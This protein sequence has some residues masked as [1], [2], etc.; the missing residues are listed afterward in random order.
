MRLSSTSDVG[1]HVHVVKYGSCTDNNYIKTLI[2]MWSIIICYL[3]IKQTW[4]SCKNQLQTCCCCVFFC[5]FLH[6][7]G[8]SAK[9]YLQSLCW[10]GTYLL[11]NWYHLI[12]QMM[13]NQMLL[14]SLL[15][16]LFL[17]QGKRSKMKKWVF[18]QC[19]TFFGCAEQIFF[20]LLFY[21]ELGQI[22][23]FSEISDTFMLYML[24]ILSQDLGFKCPSQNHHLKKLFLGDNKSTLWGCQLCITAM[25]WWHAWCL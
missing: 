23:L 9:H 18:L 25:K 13:G 7:E 1:S 3:F 12:E 24:D 22:L 21:Q 15:P 14:L 2:I 4:N 5:V 8:E 10:F 6:L 16:Y 11:W 17:Q 19:A 20:S